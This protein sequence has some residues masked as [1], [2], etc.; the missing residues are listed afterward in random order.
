[1]RWVSIVSAL[2]VVAVLYLWIMERDRLQAFAAA[3]GEAAQ[4]ED[5]GAGG[6]P[7]SEVDVVVARSNAREVDAT[8]VLRGQ[9]EAERKVVVSAE[10]TAA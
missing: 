4:S 1:M 9:T 6:A 7:P 8:I 2:A 3:D 10:T 5:G